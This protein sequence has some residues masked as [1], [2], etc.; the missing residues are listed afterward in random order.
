MYQDVLFRRLPHPSSVVGTRHFV[1][2]VRPT[3]RFHL[4]LTASGK[5]APSHVDQVQYA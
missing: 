3:F 2:N 5:H 4:T 1:R